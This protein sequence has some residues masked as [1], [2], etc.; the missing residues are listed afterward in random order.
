[1]QVFAILNG[2]V[3]PYV[4]DP[5]FSLKLP[6]IPSEVGYVNFTWRSKKKYFYN[7]DTLTSSD[8]KVLK[9]PVLSIKTQGRVPKSPK[10]YLRL[11]YPDRKTLIAFK[12]IV[13]I[14]IFKP[15]Q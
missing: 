10:G 7:F 12:H 9:P 8:L 3:S 14:I 6:I 2:H 4:L 11:L 5:N 1:M 13:F 15:K